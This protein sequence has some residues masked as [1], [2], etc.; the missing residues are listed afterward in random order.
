MLIQRQNGFLRIVESQEEKLVGSLET[1]FVRGSECSTWNMC[2]RQAAGLPF[3][4]R[5]TNAV[6]YVEQLPLRA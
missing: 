1:P 4:V 6:F 5:I 2:L 3:G